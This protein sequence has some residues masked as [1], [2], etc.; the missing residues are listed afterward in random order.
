[1]DFQTFQLNIKYIFYKRKIQAMYLYT[2][3]FIHYVTAASII[4]LYPLKIIFR[5]IIGRVNWI[6][7]FKGS[8]VL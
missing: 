3:Y 2:T 6:A 5:L 1:M 8:F 4:I 7:F